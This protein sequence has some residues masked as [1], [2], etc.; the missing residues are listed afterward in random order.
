MRNPVP[1]PVCFSLIQPERFMTEL[2]KDRIDLAVAEAYLQDP[3]Q[4]DLSQ[5]TTM[6]AKGAKHLANHVDA[7]T[8][9]LGG[10]QGID[11]D[12]A[13]ELAG[14]KGCVSL[15]G[16]KEVDDEVAEVLHSFHHTVIVK[17]PEVAGKIG[18]FLG[19]LKKESAQRIIDLALENRVFKDGELCFTNVLHTGCYLSLTKEAAEVLVSIVPPLYLYQI[20][21]L[22]AEVAEI[23]S[24]KKYID[25]ANLV[26]I[27]RETLEALAKGSGKSL[28]LS[29]FE[30]IDRE[31][32]EVL[33]SANYSFLGLNGI[34]EMEEEIAEVFTG[35]QSDACLYLDGLKSMS[36]G[37]ARSFSLMGKDCAFSVSFGGL[38]EISDEVAEILAEFEGAIMTFDKKT[39]M[40]EKTRELFA[41]RMSLQVF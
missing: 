17:D 14:F 41:K 12:S 39:K 11:L 28:Y 36:V 2:S 38:D 32:V 7:P 26:D 10:L 1:L 37:V 4:M 19:P 16:L 35:F 29:G 9:A 15:F 13:R 23:L 8:L 27:S 30:S 24:Q 18:K 5:Y 21:S 34:A 25:L 6:D 33:V 22:D 40:S 3:E 20:R 31:L